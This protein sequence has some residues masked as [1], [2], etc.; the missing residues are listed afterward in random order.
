MVSSSLS[1]EAEVDDESF[2]KFGLVGIKFDF[3]VA[4]A[5]RPVNITVSAQAGRVLAIEDLDVVIETVNGF[6]DIKLTLKMDFLAFRSRDLE[7]TCEVVCVA[8]GSVDIHSLGNK[9]SICFCQIG[10]NATFHYIGRGNSKVFLLALGTFKEAPAYAFKTID[11]VQTFS[12]VGTWIGLA[13][14]DV[15]NAVLAFEPRFACA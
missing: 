10:T 15:N 13:L 12:V 14:I 9:G 5:A 7:T 11:L 8:R 3:D 2:S 1:N 6:F 4:G